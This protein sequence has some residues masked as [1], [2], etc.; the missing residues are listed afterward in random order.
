MSA[1]EYRDRM[2]TVRLSARAALAIAVVLLH[3]PL[4]VY[5]TLAAPHLEANPVVNAIGFE[6]WAVVKTGVLSMLP[7]AYSSFDADDPP[8][9]LPG[10]LRATPRWATS[11]RYW[12]LMGLLVWGLFAVVGNL[13]SLSVIAWTA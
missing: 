1:I 11:A 3:G 6:L 2:L 13:L 10:P 5:L 8:E 9:W 7:V 12:F 4:D